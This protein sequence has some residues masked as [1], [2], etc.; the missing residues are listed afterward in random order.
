MKWIVFT[1]LV[2]CR[3]AHPDEK[4]WNEYGKKCYEIL[5]S[6]GYFWEDRY[7]WDFRDCCEQWCDVYK[8]KAS[9]DFVDKGVTKEQWKEEKKKIWE[10]ARKC[11]SVCNTSRKYKETIN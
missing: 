9:Y 7:N 3:E 5:S 8:K 6:R 1:L 4:T 11:R 10:N 2:G